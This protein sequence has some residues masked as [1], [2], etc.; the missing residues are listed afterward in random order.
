MGSSLLSKPLKI[1]ILRWSRVPLRCKETCRSENFTEMRRSGFLV[2]ARVLVRTG[3]SSIDDSAARRTEGAV[4]SDM[5]AR[6]NTIRGTL[7]PLSFTSH[8]FGAII[9]R[10]ESPSRRQPELARALA[11]L[12]G[13]SL[14]AMTRARTSIFQ[15]LQLLAGFIGLSCCIS[16]STRSYCIVSTI[17][18]VT[19]HKGPGAYRNWDE[20]T[21]HN[22]V[23]A[24]ASKIFSAYG[25]IYG[26]YYYI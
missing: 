20:V 3:A 4:D 26:M 24:S 10:L 1:Y 11:A 21:G 12:T 9:L 8:V 14:S 19:G 16:L 6:K 22:D 2:F 7:G 23:L 25:A 17:P 13:C 18:V 15:A 5:N